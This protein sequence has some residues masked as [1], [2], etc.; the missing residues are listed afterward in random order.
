[1]AVAHLFFGTCHL[2]AGAEVIQ[3]FSLFVSPQALQVLP[4]HVDDLE[5]DGELQVRRQTQAS[6]HYYQNC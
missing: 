4:Q 2:E 5:G 3:P 1:M 6:C